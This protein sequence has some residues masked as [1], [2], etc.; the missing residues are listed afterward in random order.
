MALSKEEIAIRVGVDSTGVTKGMVAMNNFISRSLADVQKKFLKFS[1]GLA[2]GFAVG[3]ISD[4]VSFIIQKWQDGWDVAFR[5]MTNSWY[6]FTEQAMKDADRTA[7]RWAGIRS[8]QKKAQSQRDK[9]G[10]GARSSQFAGGDENAKLDILAM[11]KFFAEEKYQTALKELKLKQQL[12]TVG[13]ELFKAEESYYAAV[14]EREKASSALQKQLGESS[15]DA[16][17]KFFERESKAAIQDVLALRRDLAILKDEPGT[18]AEQSRIK[19]KIM[20]AIATRADLLKSVGMS[21]NALPTKENQSYYDKIAA[22]REAYRKKTDYSQF[23]K[24]IKDATKEA[25]KESV[26]KVQ[27]VKVDEK[28]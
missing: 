25:S 24:A 6:G 28:A 19:E 8:A 13:D 12:V 26:M 20:Q 18:G 22:D 10:D 23:G 3:A 21:E 27:I 2:A 7:G 17:K 14:S 9:T 5:E 1:T 15:S 11:E 4:A 16:K